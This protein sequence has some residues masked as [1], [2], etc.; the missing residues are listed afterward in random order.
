MTGCMVA[1]AVAGVYMRLNFAGGEGFGRS[2]P[3]L[4]GGVLK[5]PASRIEKRG[6][7]W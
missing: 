7:F 5:I 6:R 2:W 1:I 3:V 4:S